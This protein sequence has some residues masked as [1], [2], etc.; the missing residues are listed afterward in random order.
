MF[1]F[2]D[3]FSSIEVLLFFF[4]CWRT[5]QLRYTV[6]IETNGRII[7]TQ[8]RLTTWW[9]AWLTAHLWEHSMKER[10]VE[11]ASNIVDARR[12]SLHIRMTLCQRKVVTFHLWFG[13]G[14]DLRELHLVTSYIF[15]DR[16]PIWFVK[17]FSLTL[18]HI[19]LCKTHIS[20][21]F[22]SRTIYKLNGVH[23]KECNVHA[24]HVIYY[25][26][27]SRSTIVTEES[28]SISTAKC[29]ECLRLTFSF[30]CGS[31][32]VSLLKRYSYSDPCCISVVISGYNT[33]HIAY[34]TLSHMYYFNI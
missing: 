19:S 21:I 23:V 2:L 22:I 5:Y 25:Q 18:D 3:V 4:K 17:T 29:V 34:N 9:H 15:Y 14:S 30:I 13:N 24:L 1:F 16:I 32:H 31:L 10:N 33:C 12:M 27:I 28:E 7:K 20:L 11:I 8:C 26:L 6:V